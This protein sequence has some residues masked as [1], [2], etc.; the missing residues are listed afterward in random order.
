M[1]GQ[2]Q[3]A[4]H[5][6]S[7]KAGFACFSWFWVGLPIQVAPLLQRDEV[8]RLTLSPSFRQQPAMASLQSW[9]CGMET[10]QVGASPLPT[11]GEPPTRVFYSS[12]CLLSWAESL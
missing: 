6:L 7:S 9:A 8:L 10:A 5:H 1:S 4:G 2:T 12:P 3:Q 11:P